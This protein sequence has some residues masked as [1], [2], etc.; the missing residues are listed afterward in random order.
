[1]QSSS[2]SDKGGGVETIAGDEVKCEEIAQTCASLV[3]F[4]RCCY[5]NILWHSYFMGCA[6]QRGVEGNSVQA[7]DSNR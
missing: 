7:I 4:A 5:H 2:V 1:M 6:S 3:S